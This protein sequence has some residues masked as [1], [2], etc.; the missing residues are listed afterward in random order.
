MVR[1]HYRG[2]VANRMFTYSAARIYAEKHGLRL[3][4]ENPHDGFVNAHGVDGI[5]V[6]TDYIVYGDDNYRQ[7]MTDGPRQALVYCFA[8]DLDLYRDHREKMQKWFWLP[9]TV[10]EVHPDDIVVHIRR[11][12]FFIDGNTLKM[13]WVRELLQSMSWR[14]V[15]VVGVL[16]QKAMDLLKEFNPRYT[17]CNEMGDMK[18]FRACKR[19]IISNSCFSWFGAWLSDCEVWAPVPVRGYFSPSANQNLRVNDERYHWIE[20]V[21]VE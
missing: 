11:G 5:E 9:D 16:D 4:A 14:S 15:I 10:A 6:G 20:G 7:M 12:D 8:Q 19:A 17:D 3:V 21:E 18:L 13:T 2:G 1:V